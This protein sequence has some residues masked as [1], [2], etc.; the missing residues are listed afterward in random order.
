[1]GDHQGRVI[2]GDLAEAGLDLP[3]GMAVEGRGRLVEEHDGG[4]LQDGARDGDPLLLAA[5]EL[6][7]ALADPGGEAVGQ[8][9]RRDR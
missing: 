9:A 3:L 8:P 2:L 4:A 1:M 5:G 7:P 6:Q